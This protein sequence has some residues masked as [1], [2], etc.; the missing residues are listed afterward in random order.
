MTRVNYNTDVEEMN[1]FGVAV[2]A[3][4]SGDSVYGVKEGN[5]HICSNLVSTAKAISKYGHTVT[6]ITS[7]S[8][9]EVKYTVATDSEEASFDAV[10]IAVP[11][12][13]A[14]IKFR[15]IDV[16]DK[17]VKARDFQEVHVTF[18]AGELNSNYFHTMNGSVPSMV[19]TIENA[20]IPF[21]SIGRSKNITL[22]D[23]PVSKVF[24]RTP[25]TEETINSVF[26]N[27]TVV[28]KKLIHA[29]PILRPPTRFVPFE[30]AEQL[31]YVNAME[32]AV[33]T[34]ETETI[35]A[36]NIARLLA[37]SWGQPYRVKI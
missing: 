6:S 33:S 13:L 17:I 18:V 12:E 15:Y 30:L 8:T 22:D 36:K 5:K 32:T 27:G 14:D 28:Y 3:L 16:D 10:V 1:T 21:S 25:L 11:L 2:S 34:I 29:Y 26:V 35:S 4:G 37:K 7:E 23:R 31:Y 24:S 9:E 20:S 19:L